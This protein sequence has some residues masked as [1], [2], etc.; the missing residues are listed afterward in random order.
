MA[1]WNIHEVVDLRSDLIDAALI[2]T[3]IGAIVMGSIFKNS[4]ELVLQNER[5][6]GRAT[7]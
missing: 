5:C 4:L 7:L 6:S 3:L 2:T 1:G